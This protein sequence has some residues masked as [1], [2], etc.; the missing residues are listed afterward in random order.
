MLD[1][2]DI[3]LEPP[4]PSSDSGQF[5]TVCTAENLLQKTISSSSVPRLYNTRTHIQLIN[6]LMGKAQ[7]LLSGQYVNHQGTSCNTIVGAKGIGKSACLKIFAKMGKEFYPNLA[8][9]YVSF[10]N[11]VSN[12]RLVNKSLSEIVADE[13]QQQC[14][15]RISID[16][17]DSYGEAIIDALRKNG[18]KLI[19]LV[20]EL[21]QLYRQ[22]GKEMSAATKT[23]HDL[24]YLGNQPSGMISTIVCGSSTLMEDLI[25]VN[26]VN[27]IADEFP[28]LKTGAISLNSTK[29]KTRRVYSTLP[30]D[31]D[32]VASMYD[33]DKS[34]DG[35]FSREDLH[36]L[37][38]IAYLSGCT[39]RHVQ[40]IMAEKQ[41]TGCAPLD[42]P[43]GSLSGSNT[44]RNNERKI[45]REKIMTGL[46]KANKDLLIRIVGRGNLT[47][48]QVI[49][50]IET[51]S[52]ETEFKALKYASIEKMWKK[53]LAKRK[54]PKENQ[55]DLLSNLLHL[56]DRSWLAFERIDNNHPENIYPVSMHNLAKFVVEQT[57]YQDIEYTLLEHLK[58]GTT[59]SASVIT[60]PRVVATAFAVTV[61]ADVCV[62]S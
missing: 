7:A 34:V 42:S 61:G 46:V 6:F 60:S 3:F 8:I 48:L 56:V 28:L 54:I 25:T 39:A 9:A 29:F 55:T 27:T 30:I 13:I 57:S 62:I 45:L 52:W 36:R 26:G 41:L 33:I 2:W 22:N 1:I 24:S 10:N 38:T 59:Q 17:H 20:D 50:N 16:Q 40:T 37:R 58:K 18:M 35:I 11:I 43:D 32:A 21:D 31:L 12:K 49:R 15:I 4:R 19:I 23:I 53:L 47:P 14:N 51:I 44:T 5:G